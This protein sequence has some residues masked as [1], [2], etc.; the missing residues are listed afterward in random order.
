MARYVHVK[1]GVV[2]NVVE[3]GAQTPPAVT[4]AGEDVCAA[5]GTEFVGQAFNVAAYSN[6]VARTVASA[7]IDDVAYLGKVMR[8]EAAVLVDEINALRDWIT[9]FKAAVA[10][11]T[12]FANLQTRVAA[13]AAM[14]DRTLTQARTAIQAKI[15]AGVVDA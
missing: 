3:Y 5:V 12:T 14:P 11:A 1:N 15:T 7:V 4:D 6:S 9:A 2:T 10:A 8:A 13:L